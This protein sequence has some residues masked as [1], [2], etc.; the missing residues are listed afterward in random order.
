VGQLDENPTP[1][2]LR[3]DAS[4]NVA[5]A[6]VPLAAGTQIETDTLSLQVVEP[7]PAGHK[8]ALTTL[9]RGDAV[10]KFGA[11]IGHATCAILV[12][13]HVHAHNL[14]SARLRGDR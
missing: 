6:L 10:R 5:V 11:T 8:L 12:G 1:C 3:L 14:E 4:D 13:S 2:V 7:I 9:R